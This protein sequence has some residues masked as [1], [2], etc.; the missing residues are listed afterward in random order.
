MCMKR[1]KSFILVTALLLTTVFVNP[2][3][4]NGLA[5]AASGILQNL[6]TAS[7]SSA[8]SGWSAT[9]VMDNNQSTC[10]SSNND[11]GS[12]GTT[13]EYIYVKLNSVMN[14]NQVHLVPRSGGL[15]FPVNF[16]FQYS[17]D[18][19]T[20]TDV[21]GQT[22]TNYTNPGAIEQTFTFA[23]AVSAQYIRLYITKESLDDTNN[24]YAQIGD[25]Q[26]YATETNLQTLSCATASTQ[27][28][29]WPVGNIGDNNQNTCWSSGLDSG[30]A[31]TEWCAGKLS[32]AM[33]VTAVHLVPRSGGL[34]FP[35]NFKFQYSTDGSTW[36]DVS[37][38][39]YTNYANPGSTE[40]IFTFGTTITAQYVRLYVTKES[41]DGS[42]Y[43]TQ[44]GDMKVYAT[45]SPTVGTDTPTL[46][47]TTYATSDVVVSDYNVTSSPYSAD[48]TG[49][50]DTTSAIQ[51]A[52]ND[53]YNNGGGTVWL[54][55]GTYKV[56]SAIEIKPYVTLRGDY[57]DADSGSGSYGTLISAQVSS[58]LTGNN[59]FIL[60][61]NANLE[62][63][64]F[65]Y[66]SQSSSS[67]V[68]YNATVKFNGGAS[69]ANWDDF[70]IQNV[71]FLNSYI[72]IAGSYPDATQEHQ[73]VQ[74]FNVK[75]TCLYRG[76]LLYNASNVD[77]LNGINFNN[78]YWA[79]A[80][81]TYN[82][83]AVA[84]L[85]TYTLANCYAY[86]FSGLEFDQFIN[87]N[88]S[89]D[90]I[91]VHLYN[92][93]TRAANSLTFSYCSFTSCTTGVS[94]DSGT[95]GNGSVGNGFIRCTISGTTNCVKDNSGT[96]VLLT[97]C[98][99][100]G[101]NSGTYVT[102]ATPGTSPTTISSPTIPKTS[103]AV[104]YDAVATYSA[105]YTAAGTVA[106]ADATTAVQNALTAAGN[107][108][109]GVVYL[110]AGW[111]KISSHLTIPANVELLGASPAARDNPY[112]SSGTVLV[113]YE[114][115]GT[116]TPT[117]AT[118]AVT[119]NGATAGISN[120]RF[121]YPN[122]P[123][124]N[125]YP[126][127][128]RGNGASV[129]AENIGF[130]QAYSGIDF[131]TNTCNS[132]YVHNIQG[133]VKEACVAVGASTQG[134]VDTVST[135]H[136]MSVRNSL[137]TAY[138]DTPSSDAVLTAMQAN[139]YIVEISG[140]SNEQVSNIFGYGCNRGINV[141]SGTATIT[142]IAVD[143]QSQTQGAVAVKI[144]AGTVKILGIERSVNVGS[145]NTSCSGT[146]TVYND[147]NF[148]ATTGA[149][150]WSCYYVQ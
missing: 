62:G 143:G 20:W 127:A 69:S 42:S 134:W 30:G 45:G 23:A 6:V 138:N 84:T 124:D 131:E 8:I 40:Q 142:N 117:T 48:N 4:N 65:Y 109:G 110:R 36:T 59:V 89:N 128:I 56:T 120:L 66:P 112:S 81:S 31:V 9:N 46:I 25:I 22:Y 96:H 15:C 5:S 49:T 140:A 76:L 150:T 116:T 13:T 19:T 126:Y 97:D 107:A 121:F 60:D 100:T 21:S 38:Q 115:E 68:A 50:N 83:P 125:S 53:C 104:L 91:G 7:S 75:G 37:G 141:V 130:V 47:T 78:S 3:L 71:T 114:G 27:I 95:G 129:Y 28:S 64:T 67:P 85:N 79:N 34:C 39:S 87:L 82:A 94:I 149:T 54:P 58:G 147:R 135:D 70:M 26:V 12:G 44:L 98:T 74:I 137:V 119:L 101:T 123:I 86:E 88:C 103:R 146:C 80:G 132:H 144:S 35:V 55:V 24:Y 2:S 52:I 72:G 41:T 14:V 33:S 16:K 92:T 90:N 51:N 108:G 133:S 18:G 11:T 17:T 63:M 57:R 99:L 106:T 93:V 77:Q 122:D 1:I 111:Y 10:W 29:Q 113:C 139:H 43:Y 32:S 61:G 145:A 118:A 136:C 102:T 148:I 73:T 105:P